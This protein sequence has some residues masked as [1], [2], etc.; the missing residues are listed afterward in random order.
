[1]KYENNTCSFGFENSV[2]ELC[3]KLDSPIYTAV[4]EFLSNMQA[5]VMWIGDNLYCMTFI[6]MTTKLVVG[7]KV[8]QT[9]PER[10]QD[11]RS[12]GFQGGGVIFCAAY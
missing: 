2:F 6:D 8:K 4:A 5:C 1:M 12:H 3:S 7:I 11:I 10:R 9:G